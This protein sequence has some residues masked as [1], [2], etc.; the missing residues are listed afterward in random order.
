[1]IHIH[2]V[3][4]LGDPAAITGTY[5]FVSDFIGGGSAPIFLLLVGLSA[6]LL[7]KKSGRVWPVALRGCEIWLLALL[8]RVQQWALGGK[9]AKLETLLR[10]DVL[11]C[12]GASLVVVALLLAMTSRLRS[13]WRMLAVAA[14]GTA[15]VVAAPLAAASPML[16]LVPAPVAYYFGGPFFFATF[17]L[18]PW[19]GVALLG[20]A[21]GLFIGADRER[22]KE[23]LALVGKIG[24]VVYAL[25]LAGRLLG[26]VVFERSDLSPLFNFERL[27]L[28]LGLLYP[29]SLLARRVSRPTGQ[30]SGERAVFSSLLLLGQHSLIVYWVHVELVYGM[31]LYKLH[32]K[33]GPV[34]VTVASIAITAL[35]LGLARV[36]PRLVA[37]FKRATIMPARGAA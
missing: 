10:V 16:S 1:M 12:I 3:Y 5:A 28:S 25:W 27:W 35:M 7:C 14:V 21:V 6:A 29:A 9:G 8:F 13:W 4:S 20:T 17:P 19:A 11:N 31:P 30:S 33:L 2:V 23:R 26:E 15:A 34:L 32:G 22:A 24:L 37:F 36:T 18:F